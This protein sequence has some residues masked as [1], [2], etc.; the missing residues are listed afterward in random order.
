MQTPLWIKQE[1]CKNKEHIQ[2]RCG[3]C[4]RHTY[5]HTVILR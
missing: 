1:K 5:I 2:F 3:E 4:V